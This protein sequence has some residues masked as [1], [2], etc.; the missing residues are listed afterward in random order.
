MA[1]FGDHGLTHRGGVGRFRKEGLRR[2][3]YHFLLFGKSEIHWRYRCQ[4]TSR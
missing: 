1:L 3:T 2:G 4:F